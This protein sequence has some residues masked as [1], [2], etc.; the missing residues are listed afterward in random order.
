MTRWPRLRRWGGK[1]A[2]IYVLSVH[3][4]DDPPEVVRHILAP[5]KLNEEAMVV[6]DQVLESANKHGV[7]L[8]IPFVDQASWWGGIQELAAFR[9]KKKDEFYTD[10]QVKQDYK[11]IVKQVLNRVNT[12][13]GVKYKDDKAVLCWELGNELRSPKEWVREM[14]PVVKEIDPNH[15]VAES[16]FTDPDNE[17]VDIVQDHLYQGNPVAMV[18]QIHKSVKRAGGQE[19]VLGG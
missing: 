10:P 8:I 13:T 2:R 18:E 11:D 7:R 5:D 14:A 12:K 19:S 16:Y 3:K 1:V 17:G 4:K 9:G 6:L 15:L